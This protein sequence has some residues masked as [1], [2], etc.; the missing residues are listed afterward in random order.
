[1]HFASSF[2]WSPSAKQLIPCASIIPGLHAKSMMLMILKYA[3]EFGCEFVA[4]ADIASL[5]SNQVAREVCAA[6][7]A[8]ASTCTSSVQVKITH[9]SRAFVKEDVRLGN[10]GADGRNLK[11]QVQIQSNVLLM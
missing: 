6:I 5:Q 10:R 1:M 9:K 11:R 8:S 3:Q 2:H 4:S 7:P